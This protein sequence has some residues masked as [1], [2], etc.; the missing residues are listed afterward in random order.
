M[1][2]TTAIRSLRAA[3]LGA[4]LVAAAASPGSADETPKHGGILTYMIPADA[5]PSFDA[6][7]ETTYAL[8]H[9]IAPF[10][11]VL[12]RLNPD[13]PSD[14]THFFCDLCTEMPSPTDDGKT[15]TFKIREG[16]T[17]QDGS[18]LT[19]ADVG[20]TWNAIIF[21]P[22]GVS[23]ARESWY[24]MVEKVEAPDATTVVFHLKYATSAFL[25][26]LADPYTMIY[27]KKILDKDPHWYEKNEMGSGPFWFESYDLGQSI[28]GKRNPNYYHKGEPYLDGFVGIFSPKQ[29]VRVDAIRADRAATEFRGLPPA[30]I[31]QLQQ[32]LGDKITVQTSDWNCGNIVT[33]NSKRK[34]FSDV[35]VRKAL[36]LA[37]DQWHGAPALAKIADVHTVGGIVFPGSPLAATKPELEQLAG[38]W[39]DIEKSRAEAKRLLHEAG[40]DGLTFELLNRNVDQPYLYVGTWII[41]EWSKIG[42]HAT[43]KVVPTGPWFELMRDGNFD[44]VVEANCNGVVNPLMDT[45]K[46]L[47]RSVFNENYGGY[48]DPAEV[49]IYNKLL[50]ETDFDKQ[51]ALMRQYETYVI[52]TEAYEWPMLWWYRMLPARSYVKGWKI[53]PSH[54]VNQ[55]LANI[56]LDQ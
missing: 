21:P 32:Q 48:D 9:M 41:D 12:I 13:N 20:A 42:V 5:P 54:Y 49:A 33:P 24:A 17:F 46:F 26:A 25:P 6:H 1:Q 23:S 45:Q 39:P 56:W 29:A 22:E 28:K 55:D 8:V 7:R 2:A 52:D 40:A 30:T 50:R 18:A 37:I 11:S 34:P 19:A 10:Y 38:F 44:V 14:T 47:P 31:T 3:L 35:R 51:R 36:L 16:V 27:E 4:V 15:Y 53:G 43:Q